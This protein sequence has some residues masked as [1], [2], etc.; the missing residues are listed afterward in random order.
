VRG[1]VVA[2]A[3]VL[4]GCRG[5][6]G[7]VAHG[8]VE[9]LGPRC[10]DQDCRGELAYLGDGCY[11]HGETLYEC[12]TDFAPVGGLTCLEDGR[13]S[14]EVT[15]YVTDFVDGYPAGTREFTATGRCRSRFSQ[16]EQTTY[17]ERYTTTCSP[18]AMRISSEPELELTDVPQTLEPS[19]VSRVELVR[20]GK[21]RV[22]ARLAA[23]VAP[24]GTVTPG[25]STRST[26]YAAIDAA[27]RAMVA[28]L[29]GPP[30]DAVRC[31]ELTVTLDAGECQVPQFSI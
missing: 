25:E 18:M 23:C 2:I 20:S 10:A 27:I 12:T 9:I 26:G 7:A 28:G 19:D 13:G 21:T 17:P 3:I 14:T 16:W 15:V 30:G 22:I 8:E 24:D 5:V 1:L 6:S 11:V 31:G 4:G 29:S